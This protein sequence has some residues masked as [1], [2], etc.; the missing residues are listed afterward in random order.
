VSREEGRRAHLVTPELLEGPPAAVDA[1]G[2]ACVVVRAACPSGCD[3]SAARLV[4]DGPG[5]ATVR[6][7]PG[8]EEVPSG[9]R[10][11]IAL[12]APAV[13]GPVCWTVRL[14]EPEGH[15]EGHEVVH[16]GAVLQV[17]ADVVAHR[18]SLAIWQVPS[19][20]EGSSFSVRVGVR[21]S[22][23]CALAGQRVRLYAESGACVGEGTLGDEPR[24]GSDGLYQAEVPLAAPAAAGVFFRRARFDGH[25]LELP[26]DPSEASFSFRTLET[27]ECTVTVRVVSDTLTAPL[28]RIEVRLGPYRAETN[29]RGIARLEVAKG[30]YELSAWRM[31]IEPVSLM[32]DVPGDAELTLAAQPRR[33]ADADD[34]R[35]WM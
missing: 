29:A 17:D 33:R 2:E 16:G 4:V 34:E 30:A 6:P 22:A 24:P 23:G 28:D 14:A 8:P 21:C 19:P 27:P 26:H 18:T 9:A 31:D 15:P 32:M 12:R 13:V 10:W 3:L 1:G 11:E 25:A 35:E 7:A 5:S 20:L